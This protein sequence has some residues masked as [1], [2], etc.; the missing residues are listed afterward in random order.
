MREGKQHTLIY[1]ILIKINN[2]TSNANQP[3]LNETNKT[4]K[5]LLV[6]MKDSF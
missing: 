4:A 3:K 2:V 6:T 1:S 5:I